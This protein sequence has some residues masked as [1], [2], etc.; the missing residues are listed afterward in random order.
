M[1]TQWET[2]A[3]VLLVEKVI[4]TEKEISGRKEG[5]RDR[6]KHVQNYRKRK[7]ERETDI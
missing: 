5:Q 4:K 2:F 1:C 6:K 7:G 3:L